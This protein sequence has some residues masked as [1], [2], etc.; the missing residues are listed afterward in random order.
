[1]LLLGLAL[2]IIGYV[3]V[4]MG[5]LIKAAV[6]R[7]REFL[8]DASSVQF[9]RNPEGIAGA[10]FTI[11]QHTSSSYLTHTIQAESMN[12]MC[13]GETVKIGFS[14]LLAS[15]PPIRERIDAL[16]GS[17]FARVRSKNRNKQHHWYTHFAGEPGQFLAVVN[18][19]LSILAKFGD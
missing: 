6:S 11:D 17:M 3:G 2:S 19:R 12:H 15:H 16:G 9:T 8:A 5:R 4:F 14:K 10:L 7:Q 1:M 13:F 18:G